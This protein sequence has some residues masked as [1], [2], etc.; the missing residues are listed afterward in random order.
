M[1]DNDFSVLHVDTEKNWR[2]GQ[3]QAAYLFER[4]HA[5]G[6][7]TAM[8]CKKGSSF[9]T[10]CNKH[11]LPCHAIPMY[12]EF[13]ITA[14]YKIAALCREKGFRI[15]HLHS[16]HAL[17][18]GLWAKLFNRSLRLVAVRRVDFHIKKNF[19][20]RFK[21]STALLDVIVCISEGIKKVLLEDGLPEEKLVTIHSGVDITKFQFAPLSGNIKKEMGIPDDHRV[22]GTIA[23]LSNHKD[24]PNLLHAARRLVDRND[25]VTFCALGTGPEENSIHRLA[26]DLKLGSRFI[27]AGFRNNVGDFLNIF[28]VFVLASYEEGLGTSIL[29]AQAVGLPVV[30]CRSGGIPEVVADGINGILVPP[31]DPDALAAA[32]ETLLNDPDKRALFGRRAKQDVEAF[33]IDHTVEKNLLL[34]KRLEGFRQ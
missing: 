22:V 4:M 7:N 23:A 13:D 9:E 19:L 25:H 1:G 26:D 6:M 24:Y 2:G 34:Y 5:V 10:Y 32:I 3:Q 33:S 28:D 17:A 27:F 20:S 30:A 11:N 29:D 18:L 21:Y 8:V 16:S 15:L 12:G 14:G 31:R